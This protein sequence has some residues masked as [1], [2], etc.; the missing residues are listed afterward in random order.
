MKKKFKFSLKINNSQPVEVSP[1]WPDGTNYVTQGGQGEMYF[2]RVLNIKLTFSR[3]D[4]DLI[5]SSNFES[6]FLIEIQNLQTGSIDWKGVFYYT[7]ISFDVDNRL[8]AVEPTTN[9]LYEDVING[10]EKEFNLV[11][12]EPPKVRVGMLQQAV[13]QVYFPGSAY[14]ANFTND[15]VYYEIPCTPFNTT[16]YPGEVWPSGNHTTLIDDSG[17]GLATGFNTPNDGLF[18]WARVII[19]D[20]ITAGIYRPHSYNV[21]GMPLLTSNPATSFKREDGVYSIINNP[22][23]PPGKTQQLIVKISD[24]SVIYQTAIQDSPYWPFGTPP[25]SEAA[26]NFVSTSD[27]TDEIQAF[28]FMPYVRLLTMKKKYLGVNSVEL[29]EDDPIPHGVFTH[30]LPINT[31]NFIYSSGHG[32]TP[33]RWGRFDPMA[34]AFADEYFVKPVVAET[35]MPVAP[36]TWKT[37]SAWFFLDDDLKVKQIEWSERII[38]RDAYRVSDSINAILKEI[39]PNVSHDETCSQFLYTDETDFRPEKIIPIIIPKTNVIIG[40]YDH[41]A[42]RAEIRLSEIISLLRKFHNCSWFLNEDKF[43]VEHVH[44]FENG[45]SYTA[46]TVGTDLTSGDEPKTKENWAYRTHQFQYVKEELPERIEWS[47]MD[48]GSQQFDGYPIQVNSLYAKGGSIDRRDI[49]KFTSDIDYIHTAADSIAHEGFVFVEAK[50]RGGDFYEVP[51]VPFTVDVD[52]EYFMQNGYASLVYA[53][54]KY[55]RHN[56]PAKDVT[57]NRQQV[58][59][60]TTK[61]SKVQEITF[62]SQNEPDAYKLIKTTIGNGRAKKIEKEFGGNTVK[63]TI[64]HDNE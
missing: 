5:Y 54:D 30:A 53:A 6:T 31:K 38:I 20:G 12:L 43:T 14:V 2:R 16:P 18:D 9:D 42:K 1:V 7:D 62:A 24:N 49:E 44:F 37:A 32:T 34:L 17:F 58:T 25:H 4:F 55:H 19:P 45:N 35:L 52:E 46:Q 36:T 26:L 15:G 22:S 50:E 56:L 47:W 21:D 23:P 13:F 10:L 59:A 39:Q 61:R 11:A 63:V 41:P 40:N 57:L 48:K 27:P 60:T 28:L 64:A 3:T 29:T 8:C 51:F 33:T